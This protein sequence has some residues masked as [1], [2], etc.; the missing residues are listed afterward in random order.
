MRK[1]YLRHLLRRKKFALINILGLSTGIA[2]CLLI[3]GYVHYQTSFDS[4]HPKVDRIARVTA[5]FHTPESDLSFAASNIPLAGALVRDC[6][7][8][9]DAARI[10]PDELTVRRIN[11]GGGGTDAERGELIREKHFVSSE[12]SVFSL[13]YF[14]FLEGS[15][16]T[17]LTEPNSIVLTESIAR[18]YFGSASPMGKT[19]LCDKQMY[20]VTAV[21][22]DRPAASDIKIDALLR[23][24][25]QAVTSWM[26]DDFEVYTFVLFRG[27]PDLPGLQRALDNISRMYVQPELDSADARQYHVRYGAEMLKDVHFSK[28]K[29]IDTPK[30]NRLFNTIFSVLAVFILLVAL[31]NYINLSTARAEERAK[32]VAVRKVAGASPLQLMGQFMG[33]SFLLMGVAWVLAL[34]VAELAIPF[35]NKLLDADISLGDG[36]SLLFFVLAFPLTAVLAGAWPAFVLSGFQPVK[37]LKGVVMR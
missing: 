3:Y 30:G 8:V 16:A 20:H 13:F 10:A 9:E 27:R 25:F 18:K 35:F 17:A 14:Q 29:L 33:E 15:P 22:A 31:L 26:T 32:E 1:V 2:T 37:V 36:S 19:L 23:K 28:G 24:N 21:I 5:V 7:L 4:Y 6:P 34:G 12:Q 11:P